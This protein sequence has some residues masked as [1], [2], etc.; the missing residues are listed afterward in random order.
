MQFFIIFFFDRQAPHRP[1]NNPNAS[2]FAQKAG[3]SDVCPRCGKTVYAAEKVIGG[4]N[5]RNMFDRKVNLS[6]VHVQR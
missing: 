5:V 1:T 4:G 3:D 6:P 2:K